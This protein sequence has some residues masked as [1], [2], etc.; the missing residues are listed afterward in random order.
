MNTRFGS[1]GGQYVPETLMNAVIELSDAY[2]KYSKDENFIKELDDLYKKYANRPSL[3]YYAEEMTKDL[4]GAKIYLKR[5]DLNHTGSHKNNNVLGQIHLA[6]K[7]GKTRIIAETGAG[8]HGVAVATACA[9]MKM[10]TSPSPH[11]APTAAHHSTTTPLP[12]L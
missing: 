5:E 7:M 6:K 11:S 8:Q 4:G 10:S 3:L 2:E 12:T 1:F 9:L